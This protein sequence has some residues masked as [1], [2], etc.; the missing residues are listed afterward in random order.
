MRPSV[1]DIASMLEITAR[2]WAA[3]LEDRER[4]KSGT[5]LPVARK[6]VAQ[7][8]RVSPGTLENLRRGRLKDVKL[9]L[10]ETLRQAII[11]EAEREIQRQ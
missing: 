3:A 10:F 8:L 2:E 5:S 4:H 6:A 9:N 11:R 7:R 1:K